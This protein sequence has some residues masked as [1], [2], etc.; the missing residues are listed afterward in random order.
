[1]VTALSV[2]S[3]RFFIFFRG[4][5]RSIETL[6]SGNSVIQIAFSFFPLASLES[7][8][9]QFKT[10]WKLFAFDRIMWW[11]IYTHL[12]AVKINKQMKE[13]RNPKR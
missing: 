6:F 5:R 2:E 8:Y 12:K 3:S 10:V 4:Q 13:E 7:V 11:N 1:M 9:F